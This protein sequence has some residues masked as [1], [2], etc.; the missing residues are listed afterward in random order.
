MRSLGQVN[1]D[2]P[3]PAGADIKEMQSKTC[4]LL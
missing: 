2:D 4:E 1:D 3:H